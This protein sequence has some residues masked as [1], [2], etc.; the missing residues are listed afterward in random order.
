MKRSHAI[1]LGIAGMAIV[2]SVIS[3]KNASD[4]P[5]EALVYASAEEC[6]VEGKIA[7]SE[8]DSQWATATEKQLIAAPKFESEQDCETAHGAGKCRTATMN[9][10]SVFLP[11]MVG[12]LIG[13]QL[14]GGGATA[15]QPLYPANPATA[16]CGA[17]ASASPTSCTRTGSGGVVA[18]T[19]AALASGANAIAPRSAVKSVTSNT[20][21]ISR[22]GFGSTAYGKSAGG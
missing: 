18:R 1:I 3:D 6:K 4:E 11:A 21:V 5:T 8:C 7:A 9:G 15:T 16:G 13:R 19:G 17:G 2:A 20:S 10:T 22:G 14:S 12:Y